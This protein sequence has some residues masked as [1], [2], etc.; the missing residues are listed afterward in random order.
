MTHRIWELDA[1]RG[2]CVI[3]MVIVHLFFDLTVIFG[4]IPWEMPPLFAFIQNWGGV[5]FL[6]LS[7][8]CATLGSH[9]IRRGAVVF[10]CG[11][12]CSLVT[13]GMCRTGLAADDIIIRFGI[14]HCLGLSMILW[15]VLKKLPTWMLASLGVAGAALGFLFQKTSVT[16]S[17]L[18][19]LGLTH[20]QFSSAD[21]FPLFPYL[22]FFL[23]GAVLGRTLYRCKKSLLPSA[24]PQILPLRFLIACG[25][26]S[27]TIYLLHQPIL[28]GLCLL[29]TL[30]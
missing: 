9:S 30:F 12:L 3:G 4:I 7:G 6:L 18:F 13:A 17:W 1:F 2:L 27:L 29:L 15:A 24:D 20:P 23:M 26:R 19:P 8:I 28:N 21:Y 14:L 25:R 16:A 10:G 5:L 22:G 11:M